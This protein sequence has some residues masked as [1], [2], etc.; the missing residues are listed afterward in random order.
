MKKIWAEFQDFLNQGDFVTIAVGLIIA[1][2]VKD[3]VDSVIVG[4]INPILS[5]IVGKPNFADFGFDIGDARI[6]LGLVISA[7]ITLVVVLALLFLILK[8]YNAMKRRQ[9]GDADETELSVLREIRDGMNR[10]NAG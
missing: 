6:S 4:I 10:G 3:V 5:A 8:A 9:P 7:L 2:Q 1:L